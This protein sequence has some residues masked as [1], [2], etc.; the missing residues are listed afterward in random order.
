MAK[1]NS[2]LLDFKGSN[3]IILKP[4]INNEFLLKMI[5][6]MRLQ[7]P[8]FFDYIDDYQQTGGNIVSEFSQAKQIL[9]EI[10]NLENVNNV[11][12][13]TKIKNIILFLESEDIRAKIISQAVFN[14]D[15]L[16]SMMSF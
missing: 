14:P 12:N 7:N 6:I 3:F 2:F 13:T 10:F 9:Y 4:D 8:N 1:E 15:M 11:I 16:K 5:V